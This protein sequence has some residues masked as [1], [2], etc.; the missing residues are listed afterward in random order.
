ML[1]ASRPEEVGA[2]LLDTA[3]RVGGALDG[4]VALVAPGTE[5]MTVIGT[6]GLEGAPLNRIATG[7]VRTPIRDAARSLEPIVIENAESFRKRYG[8]LAA[9]VSS[10]RDRARVAFPLRAGDVTIG[11]VTLGFPPR[12]FDANELDF[13]VAMAN[14]SAH[15][16]E[17][18]RLSDAE[19]QARGMLDIVVAQMPVGVTIVGKDGRIR[20]RN[21]A[22]D[23]MLGAGT[24]NG[25]EGA[26]EPEGAG[27]A[28]AA[29]WTALRSDGSPMRPEDLPAARSLASGEVVA[30][31]EI[32]VVRADGKAIVIG[33]TSAPVSDSAGDIAGAVVVTLDITD[34]KEAAQLRDAFLGVLSHELRTPVTTIYGCAQ[35]LLA[36]G[37]RLG[38]AVGKELAADIAAESERLG[39]MVDDLLVLAR[40]ERG[41]DLT[42]RGAALV[43]HRLRSVVESLAAEWPDRHFVCEIP[44]D[45][46]PVTG[47]EAYLEHVLRNLL[48]NAAKYGRHEVVARVA[49]KGYA[50]VVTVED[51][52]PGIPPEQRDHVFE[53]FTRLEA[54]NK[55]PGAGIGLFVARRLI[56]A[57]G[58]T[59]SVSSGSLGGAAFKVGLPRYEESAEPI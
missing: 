31:E 59:V 2:L 32:R 29:T 40:A 52:G 17:R 41:V 18:I 7:T 45:V 3:R 44:D 10:I 9:I 33:Q 39:R 14:A 57:M 24:G 13:L 1:A 51:D 49:V 27:A 42:V 20:Y 22:Y 4:V 6:F 43:Q 11:A 54:T 5:A 46:P 58:G 21:G 25:T 53:L 16:L 28:E 30:E 34:R 56:E 37:D 15:A 55:L 36:R 48:G 26:A 35:L 8:D 23:R 38:P 19:R 47:D 12:S 50:V